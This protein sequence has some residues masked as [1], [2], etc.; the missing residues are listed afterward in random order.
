MKEQKRMSVCG[1]SMD[2]SLSPASLVICTLAITMP[3]F[4]WGWYSNNLSHESI[5][6][7][8]F[9]FLNY[10]SFSNSVFD[11]LLLQCTLLIFWVFRFVDVLQFILQNLSRALINIASK[12]TN[13]KDVRDL[14]IDLVE[15][16]MAHVCT[17][18]CGFCPSVQCHWNV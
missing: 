11:S 16:V 14:F 1:F 15:K 9:Y 7:F 4:I 8:L 2:L 12:L 6:I 18:G 3:I 10:D 5:W 17:F 13:T